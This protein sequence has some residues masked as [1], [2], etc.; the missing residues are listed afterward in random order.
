MNEF[1]K[2]CNTEKYTGDMTQEC[3][4]E[5][6]RND[7][8]VTVTLAGHT[9]YNTKVKKLAEKYPDEVKIVVENPDSSIVAHLPLSYIKISRPKQVSEEMRERARENFARLRENNMA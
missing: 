2:A 8:E 4:I 3:V 1:E 6:I 7:K 5:W 9:R